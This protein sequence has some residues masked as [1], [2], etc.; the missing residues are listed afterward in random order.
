LEK[1]EHLLLESEQLEFITVTAV[2]ISAGA[3]IS[4]VAALAKEEASS[5]ALLALGQGSRA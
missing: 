4:D 2:A 3:P 1:A 5:A